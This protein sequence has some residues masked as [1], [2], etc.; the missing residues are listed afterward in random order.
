MC[1]C[2]GPK[3]GEHESLFI[4]ELDT[5]PQAP[6]CTGVTLER[7]LALPPTAPPVPGPACSSLP[8][9]VCGPGGC[10]HQSWAFPWQRAA[11]IP[12]GLAQPGD[13]WEKPQPTWPVPEAD[14]APCC[15]PSLWEA[16]LGG[17]RGGGGQPGSRLTWLPA[18]L[19]CGL[20][21]RRGWRRENVKERRRRKRLLPPG[22]RLGRD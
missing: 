13:F 18:R 20:L 1:F 4:H 21:G 8:S 9:G 10:Q 17:L 7:L 16:G 2:D 3:R 14:L 22:P 5:L 6:R 15:L 12:G 19:S 11:W